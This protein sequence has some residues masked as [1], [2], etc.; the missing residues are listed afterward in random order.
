MFPGCYGCDEGAG[1]CLGSHEYVAIDN[2]YKSTNETTN[3]QKF[4]YHP[5]PAFPGLRMVVSALRYLE[6]FG[7]RENSNRAYV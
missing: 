6:S 7:Y 2:V 1:T 3:H 4:Y 5:R